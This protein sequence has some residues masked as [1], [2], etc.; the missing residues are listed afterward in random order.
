VLADFQHFEQ[1]PLGQPLARL[2]LSEVHYRAG[3]HTAALAAARFLESIIDKLP[4]RVIIQVP[5]PVLYPR[6]LH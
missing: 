4:T 5:W 3:D 1:V 2:A 6:A